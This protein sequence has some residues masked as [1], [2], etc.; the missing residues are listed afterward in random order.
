MFDFG[1]T[2]PVDGLKKAREKAE[3]EHAARSMMIDMLG[4]MM[5]ESDIPESKKIEIRIALETKKLTDKINKAF[6][7][8][9]MPVRDEEKTEALFPLRKEAYEYLQ[10]VS[11]GIDTFLETHPAPMTEGD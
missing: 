2:P 5:L 8:Y 6:L 10:L 4:S 9:A 7:S 1:V 11:A 3:A